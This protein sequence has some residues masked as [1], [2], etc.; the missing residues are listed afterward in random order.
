MGRM[1]VTARTSSWGDAS[2]HR[3]NGSWTLVCRTCQAPAA[4]T[5]T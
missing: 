5:L 4:S 1:T 3:S 2:G